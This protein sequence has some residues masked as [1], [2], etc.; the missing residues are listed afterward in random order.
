[1]HSTPESALLSYRTQDMPGAI[2]DAVYSPS[3][4]MLACS[5]DTGDLVFHQA[6][7]NKRFCP[8]KTENEKG[9]LVDFLSPT[10]LVHTTGKNLQVLDLKK[11]E[12]SCLFSAHKS[13]ICSIS[14]SSM[15]RNTISVGENEMY[16]WDVRE[17]SAH[18]R[19]PVQGR[20][21]V[22]YSPD[23]RVFV[24]LFEGMKE[25]RL[26]DV[27]SYF[28]GP[29]RTKKL[30]AEK[31]TDM[32]FSPDGFGMA[33]FQESGIGIADGFS[34]DITMQLAS[35]F[36][37]AGCFTQDSRS[38]VFTTGP[39][40]VS[41]ATLPEP[42]GVPIFSVDSALPITGLRYNLCFEQV[43]VLHGQLTF[44]QNSN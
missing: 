33:L 31:Y 13:R 3:G 12:Y 26:F 36:S 30:E 4:E 27:R 18:A 40:E 7:T 21:I 29:Y 35:D 6:V 39:H 42:K 2:S 1:M 9:F 34:G 16:L 11:E 20:P 43:A 38:F 23:G 19:L 32:Q 41:M 37:Q 15:F 24:V 17:R 28:A 5:L 14:T 8:I 25:M 10:L 44:L 22:R